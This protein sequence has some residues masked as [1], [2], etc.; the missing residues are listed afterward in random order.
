[1]L[2]IKVSFC[3]EILESANLDNFNE[4][5]QHSFFFKKMKSAKAFNPSFNLSGKA[6]DLP[7]F[8]DF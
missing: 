2:G 6:I 8:A 1:M 5:P 3:V 4:I 7:M